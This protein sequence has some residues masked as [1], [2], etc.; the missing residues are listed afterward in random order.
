MINRLVAHRGD[1]KTY[2]ENSLFALQK[3][4]ELGFLYIELDI[5]LS[6]DLVPIVIHDESAKRTTEI[7]KN[8]NDLEAKELQT[9]V[10]LSSFEPN[11]KSRLLNIAM[12]KDAIELLSSYSRINLFVEV[13]KESIEHFGVEVVM[14]RVIKDVE[15]AK[16]N[17]I[18]ISFVDKVIEYVKKLRSF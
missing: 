2:P 14:D 13:K 15:N 18:I 1:M 16:L 4:A 11:H 3:S 8:V 5:Q 17:I 12:L 6:K 9:M 10:L 7:G